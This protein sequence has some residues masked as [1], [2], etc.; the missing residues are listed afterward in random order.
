MSTKPRTA[1]GIMLGSAYERQWD[2]EREWIDAGVVRYT[3][4]VQR[5]IG[6]GDGASLRTSEQAICSWLEPVV[7]AVLA[8]HSNMRAGRAGKRLTDFA[9]V[10]MRLDAE[11]TALIGLRRVVS[12]TLKSH[13]VTLSSLAYSIG[14][15][16]VEQIHHD[17]YQDEYRQHMDS[18]GQV[19][20]HV[21]PA[22]LRRWLK[23][24]KKLDY[25]SV[26]VC[27][28][29]GLWLYEI[30]E[31]HCL[32]QDNDGDWRPAFASTLRRRDR[33]RPARVAAMSERAAQLFADGHAH[34]SYLRPRMSSMIVPPMAWHSDSAGLIEGGYLSIRTPLVAKQRDEHGKLFKR[35]LPQHGMD[36]VTAMGRV[37]WRINGRLL[38]LLERVFRDGGNV[39]GLPPAE[40]RPPPAKVNGEVTK[41]W[42]RE[43]A[44]IHAANVTDRSK[45]FSLLS[46]ISDARRIHRDGVCYQPHQLDFRGRCYPMPLACNHH[47]ADPIRALW[48]F[49][50]GETPDL[51]WLQIHAANCYGHDKVPFDLRVQWCEDNAGMISDVARNPAETIEAWSEADEPWQF[52]AACMAMHDDEIARCLPIQIDGSANGL[53]HYAAVGRDPVAAAA[54]NMM[55]SEVVEDPYLR[56]LEAVKPRVA[57]H[58]ASGDAMAAG[59]LPW[60]LRGVVKQTVMTVPYNVSRIGAGRQ[61]RDNLKRAGMTGTAKEIGGAAGYLSG[62][63]L[64]SISDVYSSAISIMRWLERS[65]R[66]ICHHDRRNTL[67]WTTPCGFPVRQPYMRSKQVRVKAQQYWLSFRTQTETNDISAQVRGLPPNWV[68]GLDG[69]HMR[70]CAIVSQQRGIPFAG[71]HDSM[72]T[73]SGHMGTLS[74]IVREQFVVVHQNDLLSRLREQWEHQYGVTL[75]DPPPR[76]DWGLNQVLDAPYMFA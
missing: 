35:V 62:I 64:D 50:E 8:S 10:A 61:I 57:A 12:D 37:G 49:D 56:V 26:R 20:R 11:R 60:C 25:W 29:M 52:V 67:A 19:L 47:M 14:R 13:E 48:L 6:R 16:L 3:N 17:L 27:G 69:D 23:Q 71:V 76:G 43:A 36:G 4:L 59:V 31:S 74:R 53:Q 42:K 21:S 44:Q 58:A 1:Q 34:R 22:L 68:H 75:E 70:C 63:V 41:A 46:A 65:A 7:Q 5:A 38:D 55:P 45:R 15:D 39:A 28:S 66:T 30:I 33:R 32:V 2:L 54:V 73:V 72:W 9:R 40:R 24:Q 18:L 51:R